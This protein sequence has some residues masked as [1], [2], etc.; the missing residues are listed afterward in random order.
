MTGYVGPGYIQLSP[1]CDFGV[2]H[3][4]IGWIGFRVTSGEL[5]SQDHRKDVHKR[6]RLLQP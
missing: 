4:L 5:K 3:D 6:V 1:D 2:I